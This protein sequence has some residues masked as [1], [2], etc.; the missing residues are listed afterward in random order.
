MPQWI[1]GQGFY[2][3]QSTGPI[4]TV[5]NRKR[6]DQVEIKLLEAEERF[7]LNRKEQSA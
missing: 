5:A 2:Y 1:K 7:G 4:D 3:V 6:L